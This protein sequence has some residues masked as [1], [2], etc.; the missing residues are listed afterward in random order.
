M[1]IFLCGGLAAGLLV[2]S[3]GIASAQFSTFNLGTE[4]WVVSG[5]DPDTNFATTSYSQSAA[6]LDFLQGNPGPSLLVPDVFSWTYVK[7]PASYNGNRLDL[8]G[9]KISYDVRPTT[10]SSFTYPIICLQGATQTLTFTIVTPPALNVWTN[11]SATLVPGVWRKTGNH[12][13]A[14]FATEAEIKSVLADL[15]GIHLLTEFNTGPDSTNVDNVLVGANAGTTLLL[16]GSVNLEQAQSSPAGRAVNVDVVS[17]SSGNVVFNAAAGLNGAGEFAVGNVSLAVGT[18]TVRVKGTKWLATEK[19]S[20]VVASNTTS[21]TVNMGLQ[22]GGDANNDN[23][24]DL[25]DYFVL[26]DSYNL[27]VGDAGYD[28]RADFNLDSSVDLLDYFIL[29]DNYNL[30]GAE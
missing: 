17:E 3:A 30:V 22:K 28:A 15:R 24:V 20:I 5:I 19:T 10:I 2:G 8:Y 27:A 7:A 23:S 18:Y 9:K 25:L 16:L 11:L 4:G 26:S 29:S 1:K 13:T 21:F 12:D 14:P 6:S